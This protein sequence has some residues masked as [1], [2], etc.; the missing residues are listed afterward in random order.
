MWLFLK[1]SA[2]LET[3]FKINGAASSFVEPPKLVENFFKYFQI[4]LLNR[5]LKVRYNEN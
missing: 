4:I 3:Q 5:Y 1:K 2:V